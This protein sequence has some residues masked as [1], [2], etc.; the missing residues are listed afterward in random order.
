MQY[1]IVQIRH[2][3]YYKLI[4]QATVQLIS[5]LLSKPQQG[6]FCI[7]QADSQYNHQMIYA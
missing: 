2:N 3:K 6:T 5:P 4:K 7:M 1:Y